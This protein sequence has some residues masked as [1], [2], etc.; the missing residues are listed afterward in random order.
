MS[1]GKYIDLDDYNKNIIYP[2]EL[3]FSVNT[4]IVNIIQL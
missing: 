3:A 1:S 2:V 4:G